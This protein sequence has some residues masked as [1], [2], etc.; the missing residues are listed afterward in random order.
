MLSFIISIIVVIT[1]LFLSWKRKTFYLLSPWFLPFVGFLTHYGFPPILTN[2][3]YDKAILLQDIGII[4]FLLGVIF[5]FYISRSKKKVIIDY[6]FSKEHPITIKFVL[7]IGIC[8]LFIYGIKSGVATDLMLG[9]NVE[10][11]RR[12]TELGLGILH[13]PAVFFTTFSILWLLC[14]DMVQK[15]KFSLLNVILFIFIIVLFYISTGHRSPSLGLVLLTI[16]VYNKFRQISPFRIMIL[17]LLILILMPQFSSIRQG[18]GVDL[19]SFK[20]KMIGQFTGP[21][22][23]NYI[24]I[25]KSVS[26]GAWSLQYGKQYYQDAIYIIPRFLWKEKPV[27]FD[28]T[29]KQKL[30]LDYPGG[31]VPVGNIASFYLNFS[32]IGV[33]IGMFVIGYLYQFCFT[34]YRDEKNITKFVIFLM[35]IPHILVVSSVLSNLEIIVIFAMFVIIFDRFLKGIS[36]HYPFLSLK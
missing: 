18:R 8:L 2:Y 25:V 22:I 27:S 20:E 23:L 1:Y 33:I 26:T 12:K 11:L 14:R 5:S 10:D 7:I 21:Y 36:R 16:G 32:L 35:I 30:N 17:F 24:W 9:N 28:Y 15:N 3:F 34:Y 4:C 19:S 13:E 6:Y 29:I 31:G